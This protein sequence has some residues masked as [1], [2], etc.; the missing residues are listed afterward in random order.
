MFS[1]YSEDTRKIIEKLRKL[2]SISVEKEIK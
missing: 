1:N 2:K